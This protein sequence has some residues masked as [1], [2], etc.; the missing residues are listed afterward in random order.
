[1]R[2]KEVEIS[3]VGPWAAATVT[4]YRRGTK[5]VEQS[6]EDT[7]VRVHGSWVDAA[8][9]S[10]ADLNIPS[11]DERNLNLTTSSS[12]ST[13]P[14]VVIYLL[15]SWFFGLAGIWDVLLQPRRAFGAV[16]R[17]K[18]KW[19]GIEVI[20]APLTGIFTWAYYAIRIRPA[21]VRAG[22]RRARTGLRAFLGGL[23]KM[24]EGGGG[25]GSSGRAHTASAVAPVGGGTKPAA[26]L[27]F[28]TAGPQTRPCNQ[29]GCHAGRIRCTTCSGTGKVPN[30]NSTPPSTMQ[31]APCGGTGQRV[32]HWCKGTG[33]VPA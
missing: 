14:Y 26:P 7:F 9:P 5:F 30:Y 18:L 6:E 20:G 24:L 27:S 12:S 19:L 29:E 23:G 3:T 31:C 1:V 21:L 11:S 8:S 15:A 17:S 32:H 10:V 2:V 33:R 16:E 22:G 4:I 28:E 25:G 13:S